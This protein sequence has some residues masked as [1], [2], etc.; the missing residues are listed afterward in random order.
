MSNKILKI[1]FIGY[2]NIAKAIAKSLTCSSHYQ[3]RAA[4]PSLQIGRDAD[5]IATHY[6]NQAILNDADIIILAVKPSKMQEVLLEIIQSIPRHCV[7]ISVAAGLDLSWLEKR[8]PEAQPIVRAMPNIAIAVKE[9]ATPLVANQ[10][11]SKKQ[12]DSVTSL[13]ECSGMIA[14]LDTEDQ[15]DI[16]TALSGSGPA[17]IFLFLEIIANSAEKLGLPKDMAK[18]FTLQT[19]I[20]A[21]VLAKESQIEF[22]SLREKVTSSGGTTAAAI[23]VFQEQDIDQVIYKAMEAAYRRAIELGRLE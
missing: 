10:F 12:K 5:G 17:Y 14:W 4:A 1:S 16:F 11:V 3:L 7:I 8:L 2:G 22:R 13:F 20:G 6:N 9:G 15:M 23:Q 19:F 18:K 21:S